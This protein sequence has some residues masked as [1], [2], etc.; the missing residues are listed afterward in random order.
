[1]TASRRNFIRTTGLTALGLGLLPSLSRSATFSNTFYRPG[2]LL[3][4]TPESQ[5]VSSTTILNFVRAANASGLDW[6]SFMLLRHG[7]VIAEG[8]WKPF[9][10]S[11]RHTLYSLSKSFTSTAIGLLVKEGR[12]SVE[13]AVISFFKDEL[14]GN[15]SDN[16]G[17]MKVRHLLTMNTGHGE[18]T[19]P[20]LRDSKDTWTK[21][22]LA[23]P[24]AYQPG[25]HFL[26]NTGATYMLGAIVY[27][28]TGH[29]LEQYL[30][31]RLFQP[32]DI[33]GYDWEKSPQGL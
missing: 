14:P 23:Q 30:A 33:K 18:D 25:S 10:P 7:H 5:G 12:L 6:H 21:A 29:T 19:M 13:D 24:V 4:M 22:F 16:L 27:K 17:Q 32:L 9:E 8:W 2:P 11:F 28:V 3:R 31:P 26:Y 20:K 15:V 1:M